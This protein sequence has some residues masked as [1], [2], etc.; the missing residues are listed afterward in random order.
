MVH[1]GIPPMW[2]VGDAVDRAEEVE[3]VLRSAACT[4]FFGA[5]YGNEPIVWRDDLSGMARLRVITN[6]LT[7]M[8]YCTKKGKLDLI[9]KGPTLVTNALKGKKVAPWFTYSERLTKNDTIIFGHWDPKAWA[10]S[11]PRSAHAL[12]VLATFPADIDGA[13]FSACDPSANQRDSSG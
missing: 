12:S 1:A 2:T 13:T 6:Y 10:R 8:R 5:M 4:E 7:R 9:N 11:F 3:R